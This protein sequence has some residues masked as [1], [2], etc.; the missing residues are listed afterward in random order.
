VGDD[1]PKPSSALVTGCVIC[2]D[3]DGAAKGVSSYLYMCCGPEGR[4]LKDLR[5]AADHG[6][7]NL[8]DMYGRWTRN[9]IN[10]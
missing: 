5:V 6:R 4:T 8:L 1:V 9:L 10:N 3:V 2:F 7:S